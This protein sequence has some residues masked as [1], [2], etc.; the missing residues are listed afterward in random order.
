MCRIKQWAGRKVLV[1][2]LGRFA[3]GVGVSRYLAGQG[4]DV[5]V[6]DLSGP[7]KLA[8][9]LRQ[10]E[11]LP[12]TFHLGGHREKDFA[13][14]D[15]IVVNPA[16]PKDS[17]WL[18]I[19]CKHG[20]ATTAEMNIFFANCPATIVGVTGSNGKST[21]TAMTG[22]VLRVGKKVWVGGNIGNKSLLAEI[23]R[24]GPDDVVVLELSSFQLYDLAELKRS[25]QVAV[26]TNISPNHL[27]RHGSMD[28]YI[29]AKQH[30][31]RYQGKK[32]V[33]VLNRLDKEVVGW[34]GLTKGRVV[35]YPQE[36]AGQS[37]ALPKIE[38]RVPGEHNQLNAAAALAVG[39]VFGIEEKAAREALVKFKG[40]E[41]RL[42]FIREL[43]GVRYY[44]DS[45]A[46]TPQSVLA[47]VDSFAEKK[48][49]ILGGYDKKL[50]FDELAVKITGT[51]E[52]V[53]LLG[54]V[55]EKLKGS[56]EQEKRR[57]NEALPVCVQVED[58]AQ[59]VAAARGCARDGM[60]VLLSPACASYD[61]FNNFQER[62]KLF[63]KLVFELL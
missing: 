53:V 5:T 56:I 39:K 37:D 20:T 4:A 48:V 60:V 34:E 40:L 55:R 44:N 21:T 58:L 63:K 14:A 11:G 54:Q 59:A 16:V 18:E 38:L 51:V 22:E 35:W 2:G 8:E 32:D 36:C 7:E 43:E 25:P 3:G 10:L 17:P 42:E 27:D 30:I 9:S 19:A 12:I 15:I 57:R 33:A 26:V 6:T 13:E 50:P 45:I 28:E 62:G 49:I 52:A 24:I 29:R 46:T 31:L 41:H 23:G 61:M 1:M 47:A